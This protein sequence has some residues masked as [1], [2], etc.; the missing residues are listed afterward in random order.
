MF[1]FL[2]FIPEKTLNEKFILSY[3]WPDV[4]YKTFEVIKYDYFIWIDSVKNAQNTRPILNAYNKI[5]LKAIDPTDSIYLHFI[6]GYY[7]VPYWTDTVKNNL[8]IDSIKFFYNNSYQTNFT[9]YTP[10]DTLIIIKFLSQIPK[11]SLFKVEIYYKGTVNRSGSSFGGGLDLKQ[12]S[13]IYADNEPFGLRRWLPSFDL[14]Y[15][16]P[17][18]VEARIKVKNNWKTIANGILIDSIIEGNWITYHYRESYSIAPYLIVFASSPS[19]NI[20]TQTWSYNNI[21]MPVYHYLGPNNNSPSLYLPN[22]LTIFSNVYGIYPFYNEKYAEVEIFEGFFGGAMEDQTNTFTKVTNNQVLSAHELAHQW[23][24]D[25]VTCA[26]FKDIFINESFATFSEAVYDEYALGYGDLGN[27]RGY[28]G[29]IHCDI[30]RYLNYGDYNKPIYNP[31]PT[32]G[33]VFDGAITYSKGSAVLHALRLLFR[34]IYNDSAIGDQKFFQALNYYGNKRKFSYARIVDFENDIKEFLNI[35]NKDTAIGYFFYQWI[36]KPGHP[37]FKFTL[38]KNF[39]GSSY[40]LY[41]TLEQVQSTNW[42][43]F[44]ILKFPIRIK[45]SD[46]TQIDTFIDVDSLQIQTFYFN[47]QKEPVGLMADYYNH[48]IDESNVLLTNENLSRIFY[49]KFSKNLLGIN[50]PTNGSAYIKIYSIDGRLLFK[51][52]VYL[53]RGQNKINIKLQK[54]I[55]IIDING[56]F[57]YRNKFIAS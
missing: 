23:W 24:G 34:A 8:T 26:T 50:A 18:T 37:K 33:D 40:D 9:Y 11:D 20:Q 15:E 38:S 21:N 27:C 54:G 30:S 46:N 22:M 29:Q 43:K 36:Y 12:N 55:Y 52:D 57:K 25:M 6:K 5:T 42:A 7:V 44:R 49:V 41:I 39:N 4:E 53:N 56:D 10:G 48:Y 16:K 28:M 51:K 17:E 3:T 47:F 45:F 2:S 19:F 13:I 31:G 35:E 1:F 14:P 32:L